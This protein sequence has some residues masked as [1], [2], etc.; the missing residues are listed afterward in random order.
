M[1]DVSA[2][3]TA[4]PGWIRERIA[5]IKAAPAL[6]WSWSESNVLYRIGFLA[7]AA[8]FAALLIYVIIS[9]ILAI[10]GKRKY[11]PFM[12]TALV[13]LICGLLCVAGNT[14]RSYQVPE[15]ETVQID[16]GE[17]QSYGQYSLASMDSVGSPAWRLVDDTVTWR[18]EDDLILQLT[19]LRDVCAESRYELCA[20]EHEA[21]H[22]LTMESMS[23][24][25]DGQKG[26]T[27]TA[28]IELYIFPKT[29][30]ADEPWYLQ[31]GE[32]IRA[33]SVFEIQQG[34]DPDGNSE[35]FVPETDY[36]IYENNGD[37]VVFSVYYD[38]RAY[39]AMCYARQ[40]GSDLV[41]GVSYA[42]SNCWD[43]SSGFQEHYIF[44]PVL[45]QEDRDFLTG[46]LNILFD[47][48]INL[49]RGLSDEE[50]E[51]LL[52]DRIVNYP[53]GI[54]TSRDFSFPCT[55]LT[56]MR[57][58]RWNIN[59]DTNTDEWGPTEILFTGEGPDGK[60]HAYSLIN[61][62]SLYCN[63]I[64]DR[65]KE[66]LDAWNQAY[67]DGAGKPDAEMTGWLGAPAVPYDGGWLI[68]VT[69]SGGTVQ[70]YYLSMTG[71]GE[72]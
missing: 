29:Q 54:M 52:P 68:R 5:D 41:L 56:E 23:N 66:L 24:S 35:L 16:G 20:M 3:F 7:A 30:M 13:L 40:F 14:I 45:S 18:I 27:T 36:T 1:D 25:Y 67:I 22:C 72:Q 46:P 50:E 10:F 55:E 60:D 71:D 42:F 70:Y 19:G 57:A 34:F 69:E 61:C 39:F 21:H 62:G 33:E 9:D 44:D 38:S 31:S 58:A 2:F 6:I 49:Y 17:A 28:D 4:I 32:S 43:D 51:L 47:G 15:T 59:W 8:V 26:Q 53:T 65:Y 12:L 37:S 48:R 11:A 63:P 64:S